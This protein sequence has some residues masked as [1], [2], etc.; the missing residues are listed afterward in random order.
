MAFCVSLLFCIIACKGIEAK[1][2]KGEIVKPKTVANV[3]NI[4]HL[5]TAQKPLCCK[6]A[7]SRQ[8]FY[9]KKKD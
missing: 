4:S 2:D 5:D 8:R 9:G 1:A 3:S 7:P 6:G